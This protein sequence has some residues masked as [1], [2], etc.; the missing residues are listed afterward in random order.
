M[1]N[2]RALRYL[3]LVQVLFK[4]DEN[5]NDNLFLHQQVAII[6]HFKELTKFYLSLF[7]V[8]SVIFGTQES[9]HSDKVICIV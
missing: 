2:F 1:Y 7:N 8:K 3:S 4:V 5:A 6:F 9:E